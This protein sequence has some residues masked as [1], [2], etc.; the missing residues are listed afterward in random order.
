MGTKVKP[1]YQSI[2]E[3]LQ[4]RILSGEAEANSLLCT[5][6]G[7]CEQYSVSR[8][9]AKRAIKLLES[10][11]FVYRRKGAGSFVNENAGKSRQ[12]EE[13][14]PTPKNIALVI[15]FGIEKGGIFK[16]LGEVTEV[17]NEANLFISLHISHNERDTLESLNN[18]DIHG[19]IYYPIADIPVPLLDVFVARNLPVIILDKPHNYPQ[20]SSITCDNRM[21]QSLLCEHLIA[22][23]HKK[24]A[25]LSRFTENLSSVRERF[26]GYVDTLEA[27]GGGRM[28][29]F[30]KLDDIHLNLDALK[31]NIIM[32]RKEGISALLCENDE[33]AFYVLLCCRSLGIRVPEDL[34]V[35]GFDN[36]EWAVSEESRITTIDQNFAR[37]GSEIVKLLVDPDYHPQHIKVPVTFVARSSTGLPPV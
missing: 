16:T 33:I 4:A 15:P 31:H 21:G 1:M 28:P 3:E 19:L 25:Y 12:N 35:T 37:I 14:R 30:V 7:L 9:T 11:G 6:M 36:I 13:V 8:I 32:L 5:E 23:G 29:R 18:L 24:T 22:Y 26:N 34:S 17:L 27:S 10:D 2:A 20:F